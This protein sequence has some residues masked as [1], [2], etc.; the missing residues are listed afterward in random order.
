M[1]SSNYWYCDVWDELASHEYYSIR[2]WSMRKLSMQ[3]PYNI[4]PSSTRPAETSMA[5]SLIILCA[6]LALLR[7]ISAQPP[8]PAPPRLSNS[9]TSKVGLWAR[10]GNCRVSDSILC[11]HVSV[12]VCMTVCV[13]EW[14][15]VWVSLWSKPQQLTCIIIPKVS[16]NYYINNIVRVYMHACVRQLVSYYWTYRSRYWMEAT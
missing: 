6:S 14:E 1:Y 8:P 16:D 11:V 9:F 2:A 15:S 13:R 5:G 12:Y 3:L 4:V 10:V 7:L